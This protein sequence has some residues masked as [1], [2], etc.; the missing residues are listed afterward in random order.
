M[1]EYAF[2]LLAWY[3]EGLLIRDTSI[4]REQAEKRA[5]DLLL[6]FLRSPLTPTTDP[7]FTNVLYVEFLATAIGKLFKNNI[8]CGSNNFENMHVLAQKTPLSDFLITW[9]Q[10]IEYAVDCMDSNPPFFYD[11]LFNIIST[12]AKQKGLRLG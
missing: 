9:F 5:V 3:L 10:M 8:L 11:E 1:R 2:V 4:R 7:G 6:P 12:F